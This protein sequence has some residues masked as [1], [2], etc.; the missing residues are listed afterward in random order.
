MVGGCESRRAVAFRRRRSE[1]CARRP[2]RR[3]GSTSRRAGPRSPPSLL[4]SSVPG[5]MSWSSLPPLGLTCADIR[6]G[7]RCALPRL[8]SLA[9]FGYSPQSAV[10]SPQ[11]AVCRLPPACRLPLASVGRGMRRSAGSGNTGRMPRIN[12]STSRGRAGMIRG[13]S[14]RLSLAVLVALPAGVAVGLLVLAVER[15][16]APVRDLDRSVADALHAQAL[17]H[18]AW[19]HAMILVSDVGSPTVMR[20]GTGLL[21]TVLWLRRAPRLALWAAATMI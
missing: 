1:R 17:G 21:A 5:A 16:W 2:G 9:V 12:D 14:P 8:R 15:S 19:V 3:G 7:Q 11:S 6:R 20:I 10:R 4:A 13:L 18:P